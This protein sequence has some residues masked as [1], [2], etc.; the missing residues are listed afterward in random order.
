MEV[1]QTDN[2]SQRYRMV[3]ENPAAEESKVTD[4]LKLISQMPGPKGRDVISPD[5]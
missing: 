3:G 2:L 1:Q 5:R 4:A